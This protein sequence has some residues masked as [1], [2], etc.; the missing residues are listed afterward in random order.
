ML[1]RKHRIAI[2]AITS[3]VLVITTVTSMVYTHRLTTTSEKPYVVKFSNER[4]T[5][6]QTP[7]HDKSNA[8]EVQEQEAKITD[9][10]HM[11]NM[12]N[13][14]EQ[15]TDFD[16]SKHDGEV[17]QEPNFAMGNGNSR[18]EEMQ[19][20]CPPDFVLVEDKVL[21]EEVT[22]HDRKIPGVV[23]FF[24]RSKC[25][26]IE[27]ADK[28]HHWTSLANHSVLIHDE[29]EVYDYLS[30]ERNDLPYVS[31]SLGCAVTHEAVLDLARMVFLY[32]QGGI[33][34][35]I[36]Q[37]PGPA[38]LNGTLFARGQEE[39]MNKW[40]FLIEDVKD[41]PHP[42][43][44]ASE[45]KHRAL[46]MVLMASLSFQ[47]FQFTNASATGGYQYNRKGIYGEYSYQ[48]R[49]QAYDRNHTISTKFYSPETTIG[50]VHS[51]RM[52]GDLFTQLHLSN[53]TRDS[54][55]FTESS[56]GCAVVLLND[57]YKVDV[58]SLLEVAG[59]HGASDNGTCPDGQ[60]Y[61]S[62][63]FRPESIM[64]GRKIPKIIH[65]TSKSK[66]FT[67]RFAE[68]IDRWR[69]EGHSLFL[70]D[71]PAVDRLF[72]KD[73]PE[74]PLLKHVRSCL[75]SGAGLADLWR[76]LMIWEYGGV[77]TDID[78]RPGKLEVNGTLI[79]DADDAFFEVE[80]GGFPSQYYFGGEIKTT[81][82]YVRLV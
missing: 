76:Y 47:F 37:I 51:H 65:M 28:M 21:P 25:L 44:I 26:P 11:T 72:N 5:K 31:K 43:F 15:A 74:F 81:I 23:H 24:V 45:P 42:R 66:C 2:T 27:I 7:S 46:H 3:V 13:A 29:K 35:D 61:I 69:F 34:V 60:V 17:N 40:Q 59:G 14:S 12:K 75:N 10:E 41:Y 39:P 6:K 68:N 52:E 16:D 58:E 18:T 9:M 82:V 62:N 48:S 8:N 80:I 78:D 30:K 49:F 32:D 22:H 1:N 54:I 19:S 63:T 77:Y 73:W 67:K 33:S 50:I 53:K 4:P 55:K 71:N 36:D 56:E 70:H 79:T 38:F 57:S 20:E 64:A